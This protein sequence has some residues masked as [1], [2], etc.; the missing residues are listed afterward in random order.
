[1]FLL[2]F[3]RFFMEVSR[4]LPQ[5]LQPPQGFR[6]GVLVDRFGSAAVV[7]FEV[8]GSAKMELLLQE[9]RLCLLLLAMF[10]VSF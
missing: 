3:S 6:P 10:V 1:M 4:F 8:L 9:A 7:T 2:G 5:K